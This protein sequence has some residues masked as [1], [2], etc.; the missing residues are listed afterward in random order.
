MATFVAE[1]STMRIRRFALVGLFAV[2]MTFVASGVVPRADAADTFSTPYAVASETYYRLDTANGRMGVTLHAEYRNENSKELA[3]LPVFIMPGA[4]NLTVTTGGQSLEMKVVEGNEAAVGAAGVATVTLPAPLKQKNRITLEA[5]YDVAP[6]SGGKL[7]T[8]E[9]GLIETPFIGQGPGSFVLVDV[10]ASGDT[11]LDPGCL[12]ATDQPKDVKTD[13][14]V[15]WVCG[16]VSVIALNGDDPDVLK[17]CA[18]M[19]DKCRQRALGSTFSAYVQ[20]VTD[21]TKSAKL[22]GDVLMPS[23]KTVHMQLKYFKRDSAWAQRQFAIAEK[24]FPRLEQVFGFPYPR[25]TVTMRQSHHIEFIGA[26]GLAFNDGGDVLLST[27][28]GADDEATVHELAHQWSTYKHFKSSFM[29]EGLAEYGL[30][31]LA[32]ELGIT[33]RD[34]GWQSFGLNEPLSTWSNDLSGLV[35]EYFYGRSGSFWL[36]YRDAIGGAENMTTVLSRMDDEQS[37]WPL[38]AGWFMDQGEWVSGKN[39]DQ[40]F[41]DWVYQPLT[42]KPLLEQRR[43]AHDQVTALQA[44]AQTLGLSGMPSDIYDNLIAWVFDPVADQVVKANHV[45]DSYAEVVALSQ[46][47]GL[48]QPEGVDQSWGKKR[49]SDTLVVVENQRQAMN[50]ILSSAKQLESKPADSPAWAKLS[51]AKDKYSAGDFAGAKSSAAAAVTSAYNEVAA[52]KMIDIAKKKQSEFSPNFFGRIGMMFTHPDGDLKKAEAAQAAGD[53]SA[54]LKLAKG[55][56]TT[57]DSA[58]ERG[59]QRLAIMAGLMCALTFGVWFLLKRLETPVSVKRLGQGHVLEADGERRGS[60]K[61]WEN[62]N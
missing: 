61:D 30:R 20:S 33:P 41:L 59:I 31:T 16:E 43:A 19:D 24:A 34:W 55:A 42:A 4:Q 3:V 62:S 10:P 23:G 40:L 9:P 58:T 53:G 11:Y 45:L 1:G 60:W 27:D 18:A 36:A 39:L 2:L 21:L 8:L 54:A 46:G 17:K 7:M 26:A 50:T 35:T 14:L 32:P 52:G 44:R 47:A 51:E 49:V 5:S 29:V 13:G 48:G 38:D 15:R 6:R 57:W 28:T 12:R 37:F 22:E 56:Y 25:D